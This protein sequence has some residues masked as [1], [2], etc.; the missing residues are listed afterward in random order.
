MGDRIG[1]LEEDCYGAEG[2]VLRHGDALRDGQADRDGRVLGMIGLCDAEA[3]QG[4]VVEGRAPLARMIAMQ[5]GS[6]AASGVCYGARGVNVYGLD[7]DLL[8]VKQ[9][10]RLEALGFTALTV[11][12]LRKDVSGDASS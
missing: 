4:D 9:A 6:L 8:D 12:T 2:R 5:D 10:I 1:Y 7:T 3:A 11:I